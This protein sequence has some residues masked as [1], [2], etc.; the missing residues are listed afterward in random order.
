MKLTEGSA[1]DRE[2]SSAD[3]KW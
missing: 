1:C 2:P 3:R